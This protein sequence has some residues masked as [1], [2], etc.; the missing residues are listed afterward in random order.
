MDPR[1]S[2]CGAI[3]AQAGIVGRPLIRLNRE[4]SG[5]LVTKPLFD[6]GTG[7]T[8]QFHWSRDDGPMFGAY[9][10]G[11]VVATFDHVQAVAKWLDVNVP[12]RLSADRE[13]PLR[14]KP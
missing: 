4:W 12:G 6:S 3:P 1:S 11:A 13:H 7:L 10:D 5:V 14:R 8:I 2:W 9:Q